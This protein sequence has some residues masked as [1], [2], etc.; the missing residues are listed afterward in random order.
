VDTV[1]A[2]F[3]HYYG[4]NDRDVLAKKQGKKL[5]EGRCHTTKH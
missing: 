4:T 5:V 2:S 3:Y 1:T